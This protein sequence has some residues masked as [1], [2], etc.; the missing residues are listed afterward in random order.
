MTNRVS[1]FLMFEGCAE[2]AVRFYEGLFPNARLDKL[3]RYAATDAGPIGKVRQASLTIGEH[4]LIAF[5]SP[6]KH[7]F[8]MTPSISLFVACDTAEEVDRLA[9]ALGEGGAVLMPIDSYDFALR[10][11]W[12]NDRFGLSWQLCHEQR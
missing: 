9:A 4:R 2:E 11:T 10:Y 12:L 8:G 3:E 7:E 5:D 1:T 6:I